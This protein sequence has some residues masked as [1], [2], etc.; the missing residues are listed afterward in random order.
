MC[1]RRLRSYVEL[2]EAALRSAIGDKPCTGPNMRARRKKRTSAPPG[3][4]TCKECTARESS[5]LR[6]GVLRWDRGGARAL[7][8]GVGVASAALGAER[9][10]GRSETRSGPEPGLISAWCRP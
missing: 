9:G 6:E 1:P 7:F 8:G 10:K 2:A 3:V 4:S 5:A